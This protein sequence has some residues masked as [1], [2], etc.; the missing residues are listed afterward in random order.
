M[1]ELIDDAIEMA[2]LDTARIELHPEMANLHDTLQDVLASMRG[3]RSASY[4]NTLP[5][6]LPAMAPVPPRRKSPF[7]RLT[8]S[9]STCVLAKAKS[10]L[11][12]PPLPHQRTRRHQ[13]QKIRVVYRRPVDSDC[14]A[15]RIPLL[16]F[17]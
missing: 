2:R 14:C 3:N 7:T 17:R 6:P 8:M 4:P 13:S 12:D 16:L 15:S 9:R 11:R 5:E 1:R 10:P